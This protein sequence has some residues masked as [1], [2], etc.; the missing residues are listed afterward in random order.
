[1]TY[2]EADS[3]KPI[4]CFG[5]F[6]DYLGTNERGGINAKNEWVH[7]THWEIVIFDEYHFGAWRENAKSLFEQPDEDEEYDFDQEKYKKEEAGN[8]STRP[9]CPSPPRITCSSPA[10]PSAP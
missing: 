9:G 1:M 6:Q 10:R 4:V 2:E 8:A 7:S 3:S 5:S